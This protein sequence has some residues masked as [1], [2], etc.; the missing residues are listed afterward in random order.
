MPVRGGT[1]SETIYQLKKKGIKTLAQT[2]LDTDFRKDIPTVTLSSLN[3]DLLLTEFLDEFKKLYPKNEIVNARLVSS[4]EHSNEPK[5]DA[6]MTNLEGGFQSAIELELTAKSDRRYRE[7]VLKYRLSRV[8]GEV[9]YIVARTSLAEKILT[10]IRG[11][12]ASQISLPHKEGKFHFT[13]LKNLH[14]T[15]QEKDLT[16]C[17][18]SQR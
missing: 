18:K 12:R 11:R 9:I 4:Q 3:H 6:I 14:K 7:L 15:K 8:F 13:D 10:Q 2:F 16:T 5:P 1:G 17:A